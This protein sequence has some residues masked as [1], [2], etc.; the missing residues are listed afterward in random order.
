MYSITHLAGNVIS[1]IITGSVILALLEI[2]LKSFKQRYAYE[3]YH[4]L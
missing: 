3:K 2:P 4:R 1:L